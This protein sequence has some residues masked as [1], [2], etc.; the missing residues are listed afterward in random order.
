M[1]EMEPI[2]AK[3]DEY[4]AAWMNEPKLSEVEKT[5]EKLR[6]Q[7][8]ELFSRDKSVEALEY[9]EDQCLQ[10]QS[11]WRRPIPGQAVH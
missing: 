1:Q 7:I 8:A 9:F 11:R 3:L 5:K 6:G 10:I 2:W 4:K